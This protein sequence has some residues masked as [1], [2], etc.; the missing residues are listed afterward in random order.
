MN[1]CPLP[2]VVDVRSGAVEV[3]VSSA[4]PSE[5]VTITDSVTS[6]TVEV[7]VSSTGPSGEDEDETSGEDSVRL[8]EADP[9]AELL[10]LPNGGGSWLAVDVGAREKDCEELGDEGSNDGGA[11]ELA[12]DGSPGGAS[13]G[14]GT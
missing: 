3:K 5:E 12:E 9:G 2:P 10:K 7:N 13:V 14:A 4:G 6:E 8:E 1:S 11:R